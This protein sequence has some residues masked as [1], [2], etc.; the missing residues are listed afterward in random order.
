MVGLVALVA[1]GAVVLVLFRTGVLF[2]RVPSELSE[3]TAIQ[4]GDYSQAIYLKL[5]TVQA[6]DLESSMDY[7]LVLK[8]A[9][10]ELYD[11]WTEDEASIAQS[12]ITEFV[13]EFLYQ[14]F[15]QTSVESYKTWRRAE[16][17]VLR[18]TENLIV[19]WQVPETYEEHFGEQYPGDG[20]FEEVFDRFWLRTTPTGGAPVRLVAIASSSAGLDIT[21]GELTPENPSN[22]HPLVGELGFEVWHGRSSGTHRNWWSLPGGGVRARL[23]EGQRLRIALV[24]VI[25]EFE[26]KVRL[27]FQLFLFREPESGKWRI[28]SLTVNNDARNT[29]AIIEY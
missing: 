11:G 7:S 13:G 4:L 24:G 8:N 23:A 20:R 18:P 9:A 22:W 2:P 25:V 3:M 28:K 26:D 10:T 6:S 19:G 29:M 14:R 15:G 21:L 17:Y 27:S 16:G 5:P 12:E 1:T